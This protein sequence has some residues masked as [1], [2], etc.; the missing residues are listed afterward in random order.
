[1]TEWLIHFT[2][3]NETK[4]AL[5]VLVEI[6]SDGL[7]KPAW[8]FRKT[9]GSGK[10]NR[11]IFGPKPAVCFSEQPVGLLLDYVNNRPGAE[12]YGVFVH[13]YDAF[14]EGALPAIYGLSHFS[15]LQFGDSGYV[16][17]QRTINPILLPVK[18]QFRYVGFSFNRGGQAPMDWTHEREWRWAD[19][20]LSDYG[21]NRGGFELAGSG[22]SS[23][24]LGC[25]RGRVHV[26]V[27]DNAEVS[28]I[29]EK[30][31]TY[32]NSIIEKLPSNT[33][34]PG[35]WIRKL[36]EEIHIFTLEE[37]E[38]EVKNGNRAA[39]RVETWLP[40]HRRVSL[41]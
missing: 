24:D 32:W 3:K 23:S 28:Y 33:N 2:K 31:S 12:P 29:Q 17:D 15:E 5:D 10:V 34:W 40:T 20:R 7:L 27:R 37:I 30:L 9:V 25:S 13:K 11:T 38:S 16:P 4:N 22:V 19:Y 18:E 26:F 6:L 41:I 35:R 14:A 8:A 39:Y 36:K 21:I 1:M